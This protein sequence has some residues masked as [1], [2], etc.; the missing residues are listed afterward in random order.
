M[1]R[2]A[3]KPNE[4]PTAPA[5]PVHEPARQEAPAISTT[6]GGRET[7]NTPASSMPNTTQTPSRPNEKL[8]IIS[9]GLKVVGNLISEDDIQVNGTVEGDIQS[10]SLTV[11]NNAQING[12]ISADTVMI[13]GT[14]NGQLNANKVKVAAT[15]RVK[16]DITY[17]SISMEEGALIDG[18]LRP[19][20]GTAAVNEPIKP[21]LATARP[22][23]EP[24]KPDAGKADTSTSGTTGT[25]GTTGASGTAG[26]SAVGAG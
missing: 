24:A 16:G 11:T 22:A 18:H 23:A 17:R 14:V 1:F 4:P 3:D 26:K 2:K 9:P 5:E 15:G 7:V 12:S 13:N 25:G 20:S 8:S 6:H 19:S 21:V 10:A